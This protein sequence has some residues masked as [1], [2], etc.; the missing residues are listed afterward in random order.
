MSTRL[1]VDLGATWLRACLA[2]H[3]AAAWSRR[4]PAV[5][6]REAPAALRRLLRGKGLSRV[7]ELVLGGTR[8][9]GRKDRAALERLLKSV[10][11]KVRVAPDFEI[12][13]RACFGGKPGVILVGSTGSVAWAVGP[14]GGRRAGGWGPYHG[15]EGSGFWLGREGSRDPKLRAQARLPHPLTLARAEDPVRR[16]ASLAPRVLAAARR[17]GPARRLRSAA[18]GHLAALA[19]SAAGEAGLRSPWPL[20]LHGSLFKDADLRREVL[21]KLGRVRLSRP[22]VRAERAAAGL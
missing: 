17:G 4:V 19:A 18:A 22:R 7:D 9:G 2:E 3:G 16:T 20:A 8:L 12:A 5:P 11:R 15:D 6:W 1:G 14:K 13:H 10:A 21:K